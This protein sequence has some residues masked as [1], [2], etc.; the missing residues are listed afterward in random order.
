MT[1]KSTLAA[2]I[3]LAGMPMPC[4]AA[5]FQCSDATKVRREYEKSWDDVISDKKAGL[6]DGIRTLEGIKADLKQDKADTVGETGSLKEGGI[7]LA[8]VIKET[9]DLIRNMTALFVPSPNVVQES[10]LTILDT[11]RGEI[12]ESKRNADQVVDDQMAAIK[13]QLTGIVPGLQL[14]R[15]MDDWAKANREV[16]QQID[17][18]ERSLKTAKSKL[19]AMGGPERYYLVNELLKRAEPRVYRCVSPDPGKGTSLKV[20]KPSAHKPTIRHPSKPPNATEHRTQPLHSCS[21]FDSC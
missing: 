3:L 1:V 21:L 15:E 13:D 8:A 10:M 7:A 17:A 9:S 18:I 5:S 16:S 11:T 20:R 12:D 14:A 19:I 4:F 6:E 2:I